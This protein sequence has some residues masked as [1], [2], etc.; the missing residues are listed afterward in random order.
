LRLK[1]FYLNIKK[2]TEIVLVIERKSAFSKTE[3][4]IFCSVQYPLLYLKLSF[5]QSEWVLYTRSKTYYIHLLGFMVFNL[6]F[7]NISAILWQS[8][9]LVEETGVCGENHRPVASHWQTLSHNVVSSTLH[10]EWGSKSKH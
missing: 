2:T 3:A 1:F 7:N 4:S 8:I 10:R 9:L 6:T 5:D